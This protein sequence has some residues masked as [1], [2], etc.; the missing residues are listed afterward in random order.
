M[1]DDFE[2]ISLIVTLPS[3]RF[4][5]VFN[6]LFSFQKKINSSNLELI[7]NKLQEK[8]NEFSGDNLS[9]DENEKIFTFTIATLDNIAIFV[10]NQSINSVTKFNLKLLT[11]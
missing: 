10:N 1:Q 5:E 11:R 3:K 8:L 7:Q 6:S 2:I 4:F 9:Q